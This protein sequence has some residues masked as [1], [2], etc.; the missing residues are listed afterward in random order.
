MTRKIVFPFVEK[1]IKALVET[2][3]VDLLTKP[4]VKFTLDGK[5]N[6]S[7]PS[8]PGV[9][10][11]F[12]KGKFIYVGETADLRERMKDVRRTYNHTFRKKLGTQ[13]LKAK[14]EDNL[15]SPK[16]EIELDNYMVKYLEFTC[17]AL[18]FGRK[19]VEARILAKHK[20]LL[21]NSVSKRGSKK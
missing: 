8:E 3:E 7:F 12:E 10:A 21:V 13:R 5:W 20:E 2:I 14:L 9:Y 4:R 17:Q 18:S 11:I 19:E 1:E 15:F 16:V 6:L